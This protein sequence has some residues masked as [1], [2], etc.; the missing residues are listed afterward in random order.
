MN[1][2]FTGCLVI[3]F[4]CS[5]NAYRQEV[6]AFCKTVLKGASNESLMDGNCRCSGSQGKRGP[7][8]ERGYKGEKGEKGDISDGTN[9]NTQIQKLQSKT[10]LMKAYEPIFNWL[11]HLHFS[12]DKLEKIERIPEVARKTCLQRKSHSSGNI[13]RPNC[14]C[15]SALLLLGN[16]ERSYTRLFNYFIN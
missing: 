4:G 7:I 15:F 13:S 16:E 9:I 5:V 8:G 12:S 6:L 2:I 14:C 3:L 1:I 10:Y 11:K